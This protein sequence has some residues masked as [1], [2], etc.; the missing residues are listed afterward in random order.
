MLFGS[1]KEQLLAPGS[2]VAGR[3]IAPRRLMFCCSCLGVCLLVTV[4]QNFEPSQRT[5]ATMESRLP[6][7]FIL[8]AGIELNIEGFLLAEQV[9]CQN[10][11]LMK[12]SK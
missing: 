12:E 11:S 3:L 8:K 9:C 7:T 2:A 4:I 1:V 10:K 6:E 5:V